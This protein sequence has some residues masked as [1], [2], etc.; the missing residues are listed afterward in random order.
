MTETEEQGRQ[1]F[2]GPD[3]SQP[4]IVLGP[5]DSLDLTITDG[6]ITTF[7]DEHGRHF[8]FTGPL[9][10]FVCPPGTVP[11]MAAERILRLIRAPEETP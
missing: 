11:A 7:E 5:G 4:R 3:S 6:D 8:V 9:V 1:L 10:I 2:I